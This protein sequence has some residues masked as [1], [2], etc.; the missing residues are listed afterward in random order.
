MSKVIELK[1]NYEERIGSLIFDENP[2]RLG[3]RRTAAGFVISFPVTVSIR[4][5][6]RDED[7][8]VFEGLGASFGPGLKPGRLLSWGASLSTG[9]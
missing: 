9:R 8:P 1:N 5:V 3:V 7:M 6:K 4:R 2:Q